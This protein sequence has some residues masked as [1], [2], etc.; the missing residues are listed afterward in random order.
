MKVRVI[1][2]GNSKGIRLPK[3]MFK[4]FEIEGEVDLS[5]EN[6]K[7]IIRP[8]GSK[9]RKGWDRAFGLMHERG[10]DAFLLNENID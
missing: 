6:E 1:S 3:M 2:I 10:D 9:P 5:M 7:I 4:E 8:L